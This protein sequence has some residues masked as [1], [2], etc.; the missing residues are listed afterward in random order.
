MPFSMAEQRKSFPLTEEEEH[1]LNDL[2][3]HQK[4]L[5][6]EPRD[7][8]FL[9]Y[10]YVSKQVCLDVKE[11]A[12]ELVLVDHFYHSTPYGRLIEETMRIV[13]F[14]MKQTY[15]ITWTQTWNLVRLY[16][17]TMLKLLC[18]DAKRLPALYPPF[19]SCSSA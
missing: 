4:E 5:G 16:V 14:H 7:D 11:A 15:R 1:R 2:I 3:S 13:A 19:P 10:L 17:P 12:E 9:T 18:A 6:M 8:S